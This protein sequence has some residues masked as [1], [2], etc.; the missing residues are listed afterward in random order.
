[1]F[2]FV[3]VCFSKS[4]F[5]RHFLFFYAVPFSAGLIYSQG[6][7]SIVVLPLLRSGFSSRE[8]SFPLLLVYILFLGICL[9][10]R[11]YFLHCPVNF[12]SRGRVF[13]FLS[14]S[15]HPCRLGALACTMPNAS[16]LL[17][18]LSRRPSESRWSDTDD[19]L[20][21]GRKGRLP[22][23]WHLLLNKTSFLCGSPEAS[24]FFRALV[25]LPVSDGRVLQAYFSL[26]SSS[27]LG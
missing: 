24:F 6:G 21:P 19:P 5:P 9:F 25:V 26:V 2:E 14:V 16:A 4:L 18:F 3:L 10:L 17:L 23:S 12:S 20:R 22:D 1:M 7:S 11:F 8:V 27:T 15:A 13:G